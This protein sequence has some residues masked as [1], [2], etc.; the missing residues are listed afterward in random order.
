MKLN[1]HLLKKEIERVLF[2]NSH[3]VLNETS[4]S[5]VVGKHFDSGFIAISADRSC[6]AEKG[7]PCSEEE[8]SRQEKKNKQNEESIKKD[9]RSSGYGFIPVLGGYKEKVIDPE[10]GEEK[11]VDNPNPEKSFIIP[12]S[13]GYSYKPGEENNF[14]DFKK[15]GIKLARKY[16]QDSFLLKPPNQLDKKAYWINQQGDVEETFSG[17]TNVGDLMKPFFTKI[18]KGRETQRFSLVEYY[19]PKPPNS[20]AEARK[21]YGELFIRLLKKN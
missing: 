6:E 19:I 2:E 16:N 1:K 17:K 4:F 11:L 8:V 3:Y 20:S 13:K 7:K 18:K 10:T 5:R 15:L 9:I 12:F 21:R 14:E